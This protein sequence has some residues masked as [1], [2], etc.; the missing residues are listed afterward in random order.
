MAEKKCTIKQISKWFLEREIFENDENLS[1]QKL[2]KFLFYAK[3]FG[4]VFLNE[5][6]FNS[7]T[8]FSETGP[9]FKE[10]SSMFKDNETGLLF[11]RKIAEFIY[12]A[13]GIKLKNMSLF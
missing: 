1:H 12:S 11:L 7:Q 8:V 2:Q 10:I 4:F 13:F 3:S 9:Y 5:N 6:I